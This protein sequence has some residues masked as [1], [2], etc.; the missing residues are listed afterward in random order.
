MSA[1]SKTPRTD[2]YPTKYVERDIDEALNPRGMSVHSGQVKLQ[3]NHVQ[4]IIARSRGI[5]MDLAA[6]HARIAELEAENEVFKS[7]YLN[8]KGRC[9]MLRVD[10]E[11]Y[12][13]LRKQGQPTSPDSIWVARGVFGFGGV[14]LWCLDYLDAAIDVARR[15]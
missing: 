5:E 3:S 2:A 14:S 4:R 6:A 13:W 9:E 15:K 8:E 12:R 1:D 7:L 11:R 10:A